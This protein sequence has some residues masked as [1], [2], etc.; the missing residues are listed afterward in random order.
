MAFLVR[1]I[2]SL[3]IVLWGLAAVGIG[4]AGGNRLWIPLG[5]A[6][7][8]VGVPLLGSHPWGSTLVHPRRKANPGKPSLH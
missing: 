8:A 7:A 2:A 4:I 5:L 3:A 1:F 6:I